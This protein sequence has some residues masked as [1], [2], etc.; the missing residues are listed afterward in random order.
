MKYTYKQAA[1]WAAL[2]ALLAL[3]PLGFV[4]LDGR[5]AARPFLVEFGVGL[6]FVGMA[7]MA[8]Q[9]LLT[10]R[11]RDFAAGFGVDN[12]LQFHKHMGIV[13]FFFVMAHPLVLF[14]QNS[15]YLVFFDPRAN[16]LRALALSGAVVLLVL[17]VGLTLWR[18][19]LRIPY[20]WWRASHAVF[21]ALVVLI[22]LVHI[23]QVGYHVGSV[24]K[25]GL[26]IGVTAIAVVSLAYTRLYKPL[27]LK[28]Y[29]WEI[30]DVRPER[31]ECWTLVLEPADHDGIDFV[32][33]QFCW[34]T[35]GDSPF[36]LQQHP[37]S[38]S[39]SAD[40]PTRLEFTLKELG[41][42]TRTVGDID[43]GTRAFVEGPYGAFTLGRE[44]KDDAVFFA[45]GVG[46]TPIMSILRTLRDRGMHGS[47]VLYYANPDAETILFRD[48]L[49]ALADEI[50]LEIIYVVEEPPEDW[51]GEV[52][53][54]T[55][56][57]IGE[58]LPED[59]E[60]CRYYVCGPEPMMDMVETALV[61]RD[62]SRRRIMSERFEI[63]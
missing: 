18:K 2:Y 6:G 58:Y 15:G 56:D 20:E 63:A 51:D 36:S 28:K 47:Y 49:D 8:L 37:F 52:G 3:L 12:Q 30:V 7:V 5:P 38:V 21:S 48:E 43:P 35:V 53:L 34:L 19:A 4:L 59:D 39:S 32:P 16:L 33:G 31:G 44:C 57:L 11:F 46:I 27:R 10:G 22:G 55:D 60:S 54:F 13:A 45:G 41:D 9:F 25:Q 14:A 26:W 62:I 24:W 29:P 61:E 50:D 1:M 17:I 23:L 40:E 42:F